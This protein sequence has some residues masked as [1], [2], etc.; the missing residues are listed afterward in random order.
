[1]ILA[2]IGLT[3]SVSLKLFFCLDYLFTVMNFG[4]ISE[5]I[6]FDSS[7]FTAFLK[8]ALVLESTYF[9]FPFFKINKTLSSYFTEISL[10]LI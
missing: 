1:M 9:Q 2:D 10:E 7:I 5:V 6:L 8:I 3:I 4:A